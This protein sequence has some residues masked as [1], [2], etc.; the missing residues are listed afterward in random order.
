MKK[1]ILMVAAVA[2]ALGSCSKT[3]TTGAAQGGVIGFAGSG[4]DNITKAGDLAT[5]DNSFNKFY[6]YGGYQPTV[7]N[8]VTSFDKVEV[9]H[10]GD[11]W[12]YS[13]VRYWINGTW[14]FEAYS[15]SAEADA[16]VSE[17]SW[18]YT[19]G[20]KFTVNSDNS[21][22]GDLVYGAPTSNNISVADATQPQ[23]PV[24][25]KFKHLLSKIQFKFTLDN[26]VSAYTVKLSDF[27][28]YGMFTNGNFANA[29]LSVGTTKAEEASAYT[30]FAT[31]GGEKVE[32]NGL[33]AGPFYVIPQEVKTGDEAF[34]ITFNA[35]VT[36]GENTL[37]NGT[38]TAVV[39]Q[40]ADG[41]H[42]SWVAQNF[43]QYSA[44]I[45]LENIKDDENPDENFQPI[46]FKVELEPWVNMVDVPAALDKTTQEP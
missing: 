30:G 22:Q 36:D 2:L 32:A 17:A 42:A 31:E 7:G 33:V 45:G 25:L 9:S 27:K 8:A 18:S 15:T 20:L 14:K 24:S 46:V 11:K 19:G 34:A 39:P 5:S 12:T 21:H 44:T 3:E 38:V 16:N 13:P 41:A 35:V 23:S 40:G 6:V 4:I 37:K 28:V 43:Y 1:Q 10:S 29:T 26:S